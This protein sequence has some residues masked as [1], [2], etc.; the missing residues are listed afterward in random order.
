MPSCLLDFDP[1]QLPPPTQPNSEAFI[2]HSSSDYESNFALEKSMEALMASFGSTSSQGGSLATSPCTPGYQHSLD[3]VPPSLYDIDG[4]LQ[5]PVD[6][7]TFAAWTALESTTPNYFPENPLDF[8]P[9]AP[10]SAPAAYSAFNFGPVPSPFE[11]F[12]SPNGDQYSL[13]ITSTSA[14]ETLGAFDPYSVPA[15][16]SSSTS[17]YPTFSL[18]SLSDI[19]SPTNTE[20]SLA[21]PGATFLG[22]QLQPPFEMQWERTEGGCGTTTAE[23]DYKRRLSTQWTGVHAE[24][25]AYYPQHGI[26]EEF[27]Q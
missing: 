12:A 7:S 10:L 3:C 27:S 20:S 17:S 25:V 15:P 6:P 8:L 23:L 16:P 11:Q 13:P 14:A 26:A 9:Q 18:P 21:S 2:P 22:E 19:A 1:T 24:Q 5:S 4:L